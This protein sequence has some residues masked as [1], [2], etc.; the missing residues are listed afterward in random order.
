[1][2][3]SDGLVV[4]S[5]RFKVR[6]HLP[7]SYHSL[8]FLWAWHCPRPGCFSCPLLTLMMMCSGVFHPDLV[9]NMK[10]ILE[11]LTLSVRLNTTIHDPRSAAE[12]MNTLIICCDSSYSR[13][14]WRERETLRVIVL[15]FKR[16]GRNWRSPVRTWH[17]QFDEPRCQQ[18]QK[19]ALQQLDVSHQ[20]WRINSRKIRYLLF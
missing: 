13:S 1:M 8:R 14:I 4:R 19:S 6:V 5:T 17:R 11:Q 15:Q 10:L 12:V 18:W 3:S 7:P 9:W 20:N 16:L 2:C